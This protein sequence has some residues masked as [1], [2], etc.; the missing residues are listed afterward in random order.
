[1]N[2]KNLNLLV[3]TLLIAGLSLGVFAD[4]DYKNMPT[5]AYV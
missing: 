5:F 4:S 2:N 3:F 1:M